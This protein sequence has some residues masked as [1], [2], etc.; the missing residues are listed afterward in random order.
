MA[1]IAFCSTGLVLQSNGVAL[2]FVPFPTRTS[3]SSLDSIDPIGW[4][5]RSTKSTFF[6]AAA[7]FAQEHE[8]C[9]VSSLRSYNSSTLRPPTHEQRNPVP[10]WLPEWR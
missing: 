10:A 3:L 7:T 2:A 9:T 1:S 4:T 6:F 5:L 8:H